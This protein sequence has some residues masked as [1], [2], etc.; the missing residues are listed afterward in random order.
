MQ[1]F[2]PASILVL[3]RRDWYNLKEFE[4]PATLAEAKMH[5]MAIA[6]GIMKIAVKTALENE[7]RKIL[8]V[9]VLIGQM[10]GIDSDS[11]IFCFKSL[12]KAETQIE[13]ANAVLTV[14]TLPLRAKCQECFREIEFK[15]KV[16]RFFCPQCDSP[17][18]N[19][20]SGQDLNVAHLDVE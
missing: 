4:R 12:A 20:I 2:S 6:Q 19:I 9:K 15:E 3:S 18:L 7:A 16:Y 14:E 11:L 1:K 5:E 13:A 10:T 8:S 17:H